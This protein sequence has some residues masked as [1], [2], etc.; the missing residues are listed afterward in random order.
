M[1][2]MAP[3]LR[4]AGLLLAL[5]GAAA[6][7]KVRANTPAPPPALALPNPEPRMV[8]PVAVQPPPPEV[9]PKE[10]ADNPPPD[11]ADT[12]TGPKRVPTGQS[13]TPPP[14]TPPT[15]PPPPLPAVQTRANVTAI[16]NDARDLLEQARRGLRAVDRQTLGNDTRAQFD[17]AERFVRMAQGALEVKNYVYAYYC[18]DKAATLARL[19][20]KRTP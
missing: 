13:T 12:T 11:K 20:V 7:G 10:P 4:I 5:A 14:A 15:E 16:E 9:S 19:L 18:A 2:E 3:R 8:I 17:N 6:C 1:I